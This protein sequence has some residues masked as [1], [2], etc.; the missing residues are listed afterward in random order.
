MAQK[1]ETLIYIE[2]DN[3]T[4]AEFMSRSFVKPEIKNRAYIN[5]LGAE[6]LIKYLASEG[7]KVANLHNIHSISKILETLDIADVMLPNIHIDVR[8]VFDENFIFVPK[9]HYKLEITPDIYAVLKLDKE[10][11]HVEFLGY[12]EPKQ[13]DKK[14]ANADYY[15]VS[16]YKLETPDSLKQ[17]IKNFTGTTSRKLSEEDILRGRELSLS[18]ADHNI[19][20]EEQKELLDLLLMSDD[21]R[22]SILE[23]DNFETLAYSVAPEIADALPPGGEFT[24]ITDEETSGDPI[25]IDEDEELEDNTENAEIDLSSTIEDEELL[26]DD[27]FFNDE[28]ALEETEEVSEEV[29]TE[30]TTDETE[31]EVGE[32]IAQQETTEELEEVEEV[33]N[34]SL[35]EEEIS[36]EDEELSTPEDLSLSISN[37]D[38]ELDELSDEMLDDGITLSDDELIDETTIQESFEPLAV[39]GDEIIEEIPTILEDTIVD[40]LLLDTTETLDIITNNIEEETYNYDDEPSKPQD[41]NDLLEKAAKEEQQP[42]TVTIAGTVAGIAAGAGAAAAAELAAETSEDAIKL[43]GIASDLITD[44]VGQN[45]EKQQKNLNRIDYAKTDMT[46]NTEEIPEHVAAYDLSLAKFEANLEAEESGQYNTP[47]DLTELKTVDLK[48]EDET[49]EH[50]TIEFGQMELTETEEFTEDTDDIV[51]LENLSNMDF[52][53]S[54]AENLPEVNK[55]SEFEGMDLPSMS[56]YTINDDGTSNIDN[57]STDTN[58]IGQENHDDNLMEMNL[59]PFDIPYE[60]NIQPTEDFEATDFEDVN[61]VISDKISQQTYTETPDTLLAENED[62]FVSDDEL[63]DS[64]STEETFNTIEEIEET[65]LEENTLQDDVIDETIT[66][67]SEELETPLVEI[68]TEEIISFDETEEPL[69][70]NFENDIETPI[71]EVQELPEESVIE[72]I[73]ISQEELSVDALLD[74]AISGIDS[75]QETDEIELPTEEVFEEPTVENQTENVIET[76]EDEQIIT[77]ELDQPIEVDELSTEK[78]AKPQLTQ[79]EEIS[80]SEYSYEDINSL[81]SDTIIV[82]NE[83]DNYEQQ[84]VNLQEQDWMADTDYESLQ[85]VEIPTEAM[86]EQ[87]VMQEIPEDEFITEPNEDNTRIFAVRENSTIISDRAFRVG[88]IPIDINNPDMPNLPGHESL[89]SLYNDSQVPGGALLQNPGRLGTGSMG[90]SRAGLGIGLGIVGTLITLAVVC[91][92]GFN[93]AKMFKTPT[94]EAPQPITDDALPTSLDNGVTDGNTLSVN[95]DNVVNM[96]NN[97]DA[98]A[99]TTPAKKAKKVK[100]QE[101]TQVTPQAPANKITRPAGSFVEVKKLSWNVPDYILYNPQFKQ[102]FQSVGK[103]LKL[104]LTSDLLLAKDYAYANQIRVSITFD[105]DGTFKNAQIVNSSGSSEIDGIVL[106]TVNQ[107]LKVLKAPHSVGNDENTTAILKISL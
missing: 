79:E 13:I 105:K 15:F 67:Y 43:A 80:D 28:E 90:G 30:E 85:D 48:T 55:D 88:E 93:V 45:L 52:S 107:T 54:P 98:L 71:D 47:T 49:F 38:G 97:T 32:E 24:L 62:L 99:T 29:T 89:E 6:L 84:E 27:S 66:D 36:I 78:Y 103:S 18:M 14:N 41:I 63:L 26:L 83:V 31:T 39:E 51:N 106:Q 104:S 86:V 42:D 68:G 10:L 57:F 1:Q 76:L 40:E 33:A 25:E 91:V 16:K 20:A 59:N 70:E 37:I 96:D 82:Q 12:I 50:E 17:Y 69:M 53:G 19:S 64:I 60:D 102:Y 7:I 74:G 34:M 4:E 95:P 21:L 101:V 2:E 81:S 22:E 61:S 8:V 58:F 9:S 75:V 23:F 92:I 44:V 65:K 73:S 46:A 100:P 5:A 11:K 87:N 77:S 3:R 94:E 56:N 72:N 35:P